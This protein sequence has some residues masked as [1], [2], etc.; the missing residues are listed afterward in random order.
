VSAGVATLAAA[1]VTF[2]V[3]EATVADHAAVRACMLEVFLE[4][5][6]RKTAEMGRALWEWQYLKGENGALIAL[7]EDARGVCGYYHAVLLPL[8]DRGRAVQGA[9][10]QDV[11]TLKSHRGQGV[12]RE[13]GAFMLATLKA[14]GVSI[15]YTFPNARS[16]PSFLRN[17][18]YDA[19]ARVPIY[20]APL[21]IGSLAAVW[22]RLPAAGPAVDA[23]VDPVY[24]AVRV[25]GDR[26]EP[27]ETVEALR[28]YDE[29]VAGVAA[30]FAGEVRDHLDRTPKT[31]KWRYQEKPYGEYKG[32][33][34]R[35]GGQLVAFAITRS[36]LLFD[37]PATMFMDFG[38]RTGEAA[39]LRRLV[40]A[41]MDADRR[42]GQALAVVMGL[43]PQLA[44]WRKIGF[45]QL[46]ERFNP[47]PFNLVVKQFDGGIGALDPASWLIT[48]GDWDVF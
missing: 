31:L 33:G 18:A 15:I 32:W 45:V 41:R 20:V 36:A 10:I 46:P 39:A 14:R 4:S 19:I 12:F 35:R 9:M 47:R 13:M 48:L 24:R 37:S 1:P 6:A 43:H 5:A 17:H 42:A 21:R 26:L 22:L 2:H 8:R 38:C 30:A 7:A 16:L 25:R 3:R 28:D 34:L 23:V 29:E 11:G 27:G 44:D 40:S